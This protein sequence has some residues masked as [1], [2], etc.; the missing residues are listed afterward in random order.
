MNSMQLIGTVLQT[1]DFSKAPNA[2]SFESNTAKVLLLKNDV[3]YHGV[4]IAKRD[5]RIAYYGLS[6]TLTGPEAGLVTP[7]QG[8]N[9]MAQTRP[10]DKKDR[11]SREDYADMLHKILGVVIESVT[12][13]GG[14]MPM[15]YINERLAEVHQGITLAGKAT[16]KGVADALLAGC[17]KYVIDHAQDQGMGIGLDL[18][19]LMQGATRWRNKFV[20]VVHNE[21]GVGWGHLA[22]R[23]AR[24]FDVNPGLVHLCQRE[25]TVTLERTQRNYNT[26]TTKTVGTPVLTEEQAAQVKVA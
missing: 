20:T 17:P 14:H 12:K 10:G 9:Y 22:D 3:G 13:S 15:E 4:P 18:V 16:K 1:L 8:T 19:N 2:I 24:D 11:V 21:N 25:G 5:G 26:G 7:A 6:V 23:L